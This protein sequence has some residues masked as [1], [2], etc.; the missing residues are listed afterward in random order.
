MALRS[1]NHYCKVF[2]IEG[3]DRLQIVT[4]KFA[5]YGNAQKRYFPVNVRFDGAQWD[6]M[7][8]RLRFEGSSAPE[9]IFKIVSEKDEKIR[10]SYPGNKPLLCIR[11]EVFEG[12]TRQFVISTQKIHFTGRLTAH[13]VDLPATIALMGESKAY[14]SLD[15]EVLESTKEAAFIRITAAGKGRRPKSLKNGQEVALG[16]RLDP[17]TLIVNVSKIGKNARYNIVEGDQVILDDLN[18]RCLTFNPRGVTFIDALALPKP[19]EGDQLFTIGVV[20]PVTW[21]IKRTVPEGEYPVIPPELEVSD[22]RIRLRGSYE[23]AALYS[24]FAPDK[25]LRQ[26]KRNNGC[27][28][29]DLPQRPREALRESCAIKIVMNGIPMLYRHLFNTKNRKFE[30]TAIY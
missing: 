12:T 13:V 21:L 6:G 24:S 25:K 30:Q 27:D 1:L 22:N 29:F 17:D 28:Y 4:P 10:L 9:E 20:Q 11:L 19:K 14:L 8:A 7:S 2:D 23:T 15:N 5:T 26:E 3:A 16:G 18:G